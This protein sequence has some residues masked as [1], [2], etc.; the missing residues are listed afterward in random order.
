MLGRSG[1]DDGRVWDEDPVDLL[2]AWRDATRAAE[3]AERLATIAAE[4]LARADVRAA[5]SAEIARLAEQAADSA[6]TA[7][8]R[9]RLVATEAARHAH[10][11]QESDAIHSDHAAAMRSHEEAAGRAFGNSREDEAGREEPPAS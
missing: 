11:L 9:S 3:L 6:A 8:A 2:N 7:A 4:T 1:T 5:E 10:E